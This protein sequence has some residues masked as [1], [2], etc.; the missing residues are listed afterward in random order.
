MEQIV[1]QRLTSIVTTTDRTVAVDPSRIRALLGDLTT[2]YPL[3]V[4]LICGVAESG[5]LDQLAPTLSSQ[6][7]AQTIDQFVTARGL[8]RDAAQWAVESWVAALRASPD[9]VES[10]GATAGLRQLDDFP[11]LHPGQVAVDDAGP[12]RGL[13]AA[14]VAA[15]SSTKASVLEGAFDG[16]SKRLIEQ[17]RIIAYVPLLW[18]WNESRSDRHFAAT[19][20][21]QALAVTDKRVFLLG[22][23]KGKTPPFVLRYWPVDSVSTWTV[24]PYPERPVMGSGRST[25][26]TRVQ[27]HLGRSG[28]YWQDTEGPGQLDLLLP[29]DLDATLRRMVAVFDRL[30]QIGPPMSPRASN[31]DSAGRRT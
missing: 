3:E 15:G 27:I 14:N 22:G 12:P 9:S 17:E 4:N 21:Y 23:G 16:L 10:Q 20:S 2:L 11:T 25:G 1:S 5:L 24:T 13:R 31:D 19:S 29:Q 18:R 6:N 26:S 28:D 8:Q 30:A 7:I